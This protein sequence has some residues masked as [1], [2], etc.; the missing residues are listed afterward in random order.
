MDLLSRYELRRVGV[1]CVPFRV[2]FR[3]TVHKARRGCAGAISK[4]ARRRAVGHVALTLRERRR[5]SAAVI[6]SCC[7]FQIQAHI[8]HINPAGRAVISNRTI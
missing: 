3:G 8:S 6:P 5:V 2:P 4:G 1:G 7:G